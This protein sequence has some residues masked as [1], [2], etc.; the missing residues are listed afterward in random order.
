MNHESG[1]SRRFATIEWTQRLSIL[2]GV[3]FLATG[4]I[5][6]RLFTKSVVQHSLY[7]A[8]AENQY[9][10]SKDLPSRRGT[11]YA[12]DFELGKTVPIAATEEKFDVSVVPRNVKDADRAVKAL[13][14]VFGLD[15][16]AVRT[17]VTNGQLFAPPLVRGSSKQQR[18]QI[19]EQGFPGL[20][21]EPKRERSYPENQTAAHVLGFVNRE[22]K[23]N[24]G[25]EGR[26]DAELR[27]EAGSVIGQKDTLGRLIGTVAR[28]D[29]KDGADVELSLDH[30]VQFAIEQRL[31]KAVDDTNAQSGQVLLMDPSTGEIIAMAGTPSF[32]PNTYNEIKPDESY[33]FTNPTIANAYEPGS[34]LKP[35][36]MASAIDLGKVEP[37]TKET[38]GKSVV[39]QG[40]EIN[41]ALDKAYGEE[42]MTQVLEHSDNVGMVWVAGHMSNEE[43]RGAFERFGLGQPTGIDL[44]GEEKGT[45]LPLKD[46]REI[47]RATMAFGQGISMT[48]LQVARAWAV[49]INGGKLVTPHVVRRLIS[50]EGVT[51]EAE[52]PIQDGV[53]KPETSDKLRGMLQSVIDNG[54]YGRTRVAGYA[55]G[56]KTGTAQIAAPGGGYLE[57]TYTHSLLGF[58]PVDK[59]KYLLL[60]KIDRPEAEYAESTAGPLFHDIAQ[61]L[62]SYYKLPPDK[63]T[64]DQ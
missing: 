19:L 20:L 18:D 38:F 32:D 54:S 58:F 57:K 52:A 45:V 11:I 29:P 40:Y 31:Y 37:D 36:V 34:I 56:G 53:I 30:N 4:G 3:V 13:H 27:G 9:E 17:V 51:V 6:W 24:Y 12:Q 46:W 41:T 61:Y 22:G 23:G 7:V 48:P 55:I 8:K 50:R 42:T 60:V 5:T 2:I 28:V 59:P 44:T 14:S 21:I 49:L 47:S 62:F 35:V 10:V 43:M 63:D 16:D 33:R 39:V 25:I 15:E 26:F 64:P 1:Q